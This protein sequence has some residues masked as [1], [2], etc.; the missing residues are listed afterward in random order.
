MVFSVAMA[1]TIFGQGPLQKRINFSI[2][3]PYAIRMGEYLLPPGEYVLYQVLQN[4]LNLYA[5][6]PENMTNEPIAMI[7]TVRIDYQANRYPEETKLFMENDEMS[8]DNH[9]VLEGWTIPGMDGWEVIGVVEKKTGV[10]TRVDSADSHHHKKHKLDR[11][12]L[13]LKKY[14]RNDRRSQVQF[15]MIEK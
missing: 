2:N 13:S 3:T 8:S 10:M 15:I 12:R 6:Y 5:L 14:D 4:D 1:M 11:T 9:P 7:R